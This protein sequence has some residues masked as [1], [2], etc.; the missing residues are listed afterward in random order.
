MFDVTSASAGTGKTKWLVDHLRH[1]LLN[2]LRPE[3]VVAITYTEKAAAELQS[4][5][6]RALLEEG[7]V[8]AAD[9]LA[10]G[11]IGTIHSVC[12]RL[13]RDY[14][15]EAGTGPDQTVLADP[16]SQRLLNQV[17]A[18]MEDDDDGALQS[19]AVRCEV[20]WRAAVRS[21][22]SHARANGMVPA[23]LQLSAERSC[24]L[25]ASVLGAPD[26][27]AE[28]HD[29]RFRRALEDAVP[30][31]REDANSAAGR[32][33]LEAV[34]RVLQRLGSSSADPTWAE[35]AGLLRKA[36]QKI[37]DVAEPIRTA[38]NDTTHPL[39]HQ[40]LERI[41]RSVL[42]KAAAALDEFDALKRQARVMDFNDMLARA[43]ALLANPTVAES[44]NQQVDIVLVDEF[45]DVSP[46][47]LLLVLRL[48]E[49]A[50]RSAWVGDPK[51]AIFDFQGSDPLLM[52]AALDYALDGRD[53]KVLSRSYRSRR[54]LVRFCSDVFAPAFAAHGVPEHQVR[55]EAA[56]E[57]PEELVPQHVLELWPWSDAKVK[58]VKSKEE[59]AIAAG[60]EQLLADGLLVRDQRRP[61]HTLTTR[62]A[63]RRDVAVLARTNPGA[64]RIAR[65]LRSRGIPAAARLGG[66]RE[67]SEALLTTA[68]LALVAE[69]HD[70]IA[71]AEVLWLTGEA[72]GDPGAWLAGRIA[73]VAIRRGGGDTSPGAPARPP[74]HDNPR[75]AALRAL[76]TEATRLGPAALLDLVLETARVAEICRGWDDPERRLAN[77]EALRGLATE[78]EEVCRA[79]R[80]PCTLGGLITHL[81]TVPEGKETDQQALPGDSDAVQVLTYHK[82]KGLEWPVV[83]LTELDKTHGLPLFGVHV[84]PR[85]NGFDAAAPLADRW[86]RCLPWPYGDKSAGIELWQRAQHTELARRLAARDEYEQLRLLYVGLTRAR[87]LLVLSAQLKDN[88]PQTAWLTAALRLGQQDGGLELPWTSA[89]GDSAAAVSDAEPLRCRVRTFDGLPPGETVVSSTSVE[90]FPA[91]SERASRPMERVNPSAGAG[92]ARTAEVQ[93]SIVKLTD[94]VGVAAAV[95]MR[96]LGDA[97][98]AFIAADLLTLSMARRAGAPADAGAPARMQMAERLLRA[99]GVADALSPADLLRIT[100]ALDAWIAA[101]FAGARIHPE[102]PVRW[103]LRSEHGDRLLVG[104]VDLALETEAGWV[105]IDHKTFGGGEAVRD[106]RV[107]SYAPQLAAYG[108]ALAAGGR[109]VLATYLHFPLL[110]ELVELHSSAPQV[111][112]IAAGPIT[113]A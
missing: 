26:G 102:F 99:G 100:D 52:Q 46:L 38:G 48:A 54:E 59:H 47:Q 1:E 18:R 103:R 23:D 97:V 65:A 67:T 80:R 84:E 25:M 82:A 75:L 105:V 85:E 34:E 19:A 3:A 35:R 41:I 29:M 91:P 57:E 58:G 33:R 71:A 2:G 40:D 24:A 69:P 49:V 83:V 61:D 62:P 63:Q 70:G 86:I 95:P 72:G 8:E 60:V 51:Q 14:A 44:L 81:R 10:D 53:P 21:A 73:E 90:W 56:V 88:V 87:D 77:V 111:S 22:V 89:A 106:E 16:E 112:A 9:A 11:Y 109:P 68:A 4:R 12:Q 74:F 50:G 98:H 79:T 93:N 55:L 7:A 13:L 94:G 107:Q 43:A 37:H 66:L 64:Q 92:G 104:E 101:N 113:V 45:Q 30:A 42:G 5:L 76:H 20:D 17:L 110:G 108:A 32:N 6:R 28:A 78:H 36:P 31:L 96:L 39:L 27:T 15:L